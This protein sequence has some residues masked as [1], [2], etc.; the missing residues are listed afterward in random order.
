[1]SGHLVSAVMCNIGREMVDNL[2]FDNGGTNLHI[3]LSKTHVIKSTITLLWSLT[4]ITWVYTS[5]FVG[6]LQYYLRY[7]NNR[8]FN[9]GGTNLHENDTWDIL[10]TC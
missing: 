5:Y 1:M 8:F 4:L 2:F 10:L 7:S 6:Y 3:K 9:N